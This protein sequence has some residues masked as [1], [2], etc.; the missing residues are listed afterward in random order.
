MQARKRALL[1][2]RNHTG[3]LISDSSP[4][5]LWESKFVLFKHPHLWHFTTAAQV[6]K[7]VDSSASIHSLLE[8]TQKGRNDGEQPHRNLQSSRFLRLKQEVNFPTTSLGCLS[9]ESVVGCCA[10]KRSLGA[11][12]IPSKTLYWRLSPHRVWNMLYK[13]QKQK[14]SIP[15]FPQNKRNIAR[16]RKKEI[17]ANP[18]LQ[19][20]HTIHVLCTAPIWRQKPA[21]R[22]YQSWAHAVFALSWPAFFLQYYIRTICL[23][24]KILCKPHF[25]N[26]I[27][28]YHLVVS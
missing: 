5:Q 2:E 27:I 28:F 21:S 7:T 26:R 16:C 19:K 17:H 1:P 18:P 23:V 8:K 14:N 13:K 4:P 3:T 24:I 6:H 22:S 10:L 15:V 12:W 25:K 9:Q 20:Q 11:W